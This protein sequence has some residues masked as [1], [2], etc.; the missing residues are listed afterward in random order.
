MVKHDIDGDGDDG[1]VDDDK[2]WWEHDDQGQSGRLGH[3]DVDGDGD[4]DGDDND[5]DKT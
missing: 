4:G 1:D 5:D 2:T 3:D